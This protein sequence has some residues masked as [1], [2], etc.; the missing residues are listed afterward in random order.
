VE[1][2]KSYGISEKKRVMELEKV[3]VQRLV[4]QNLFFKKY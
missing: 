4:W 3:V 1:K 2:K